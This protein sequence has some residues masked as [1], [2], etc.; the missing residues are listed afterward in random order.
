MGYVAGQERHDGQMSPTYIKE[1]SDKQN[2][3]TE[4][5]IGFYQR[6]ISKLR[7][8]QCA[9]YPSCSNYGLKVFKDKPFFEAM[10]YTA[11]RMMRC[12]HDKKYYDVSIQYGDMALLDW[13]SYEK[14]PKELIYNGTHSFY[15]ESTKRVTKDT[16][17]FINYLINHKQYDMA[18]L[19]ITKN[20][21][22][23]ETTNP[24]L[25]KNKLLC[26]EALGKEE[27]GIYEYEVNFPE[28]IQ[29][30]CL[31]GMKAAK[32]YYNID[33]YDMALSSLERIKDFESDDYYRKLVFQSI[34]ETRKK[35]YSSAI[36]ILTKAQKDYPEYSES[37]L[38]SMQI[39][40]SLSNSSKK[41]PNIAKLLSVIPGAGYAYTKQ[42]QTAI[43]SLLINSVLA[44][45]TYTCIKRDN[46]GMAALSGIF[47]L[48][49]YFGN[50]LGAGKSAN[51]YN[52][53]LENRHIQE[54]TGLNGFNSY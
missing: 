6:H 25:Y 48:T 32:L 21:Y 53:S 26:Y 24:L 14:T 13:P 41:K 20:L 19:E 37:C 4:D 10:I 44:Y 23:K 31:V 8:T 1:S 33:N 16:L 42:Y 27:D 30:S 50:I 3:V 11:D 46:Y 40:T 39:I 49:F 45:A 5:Y 15:T 9:M 22:F 29:T 36:S 38:K 47:S 17:S 2:K 54:L 28:C 34:I 7:G 43:T 52:Q 12:G 35:N 18:L 51:R